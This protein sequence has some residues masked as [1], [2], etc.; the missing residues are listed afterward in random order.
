MV[1]GLS[2]NRIYEGLSLGFLNAECPFNVVPEGYDGEGEPRMGKWYP[3][4]NLR[5]REV[6]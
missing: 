4:C 6:D 5:C 2:R 3:S 1:K